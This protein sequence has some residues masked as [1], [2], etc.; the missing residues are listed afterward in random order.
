MSLY[1]FVFV[2]VF[3]FILCNILYRSDC[4]WLYAVLLTSAVI[5]TV[6][7]SMTIPFAFVGDIFFKGTEATTSH[8]I[9]AGLVILG[10]LFVNLEKQIQKF[11]KQS[12]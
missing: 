5:V 9:G 11:F 3:V 4:L 12:K 10:F 7:I 1:F 2:F 8:F 6:G